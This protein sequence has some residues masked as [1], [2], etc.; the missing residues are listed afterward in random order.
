MNY[1]RISVRI[2]LN[3]RELPC[4]SGFRGL[5]RVDGSSA[6]WPATF[7]FERGAATPGEMVYAVVSVSREALDVVRVRQRF[8]LLDG[9]KVVGRG[10][11]LV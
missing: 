4:V 7:R 1:T 2:G 3:P 6:A 10:E 9:G 5:I 8:D 11:V